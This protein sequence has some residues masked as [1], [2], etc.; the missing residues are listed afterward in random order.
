MGVNLRSVRNGDFVADSYFFGEISVA[1]DMEAD[2]AAAPYFHAAKTKKD[3][4]CTREGNGG[5]PEG[6]NVTPKCCNQ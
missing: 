1:D 2:V 5:H 4:A 6:Q 3:D